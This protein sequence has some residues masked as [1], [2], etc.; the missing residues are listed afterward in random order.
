MRIKTTTQ[1]LRARVTTSAYSLATRATT[2]ALNAQAHAYKLKISVGT[3]GSYLFFQDNALVQSLT[4]LFFT[5]AGIVDNAAFTD[6]DSLNIGKNEVD[7][8]TVSEVFAKV[9]AKGFSDPFSIEDGGLYF[10]EDYTPLGYTTP[11]QPLILFGKNVSDSASFT[12]ALGVFTIGKGIL[13]T[14]SFT[15]GIALNKSKLIET[16]TGNISESYAAAFSN[17]ASDGITVAQSFI[18]SYSKAVA[19]GAAWSDSSLLVVGSAV[20]D[21]LGLGDAGSIRAQ[22]YCSFDYFAADYVGTSLTF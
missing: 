14:P 11:K 17:S 2:F 1:K 18:S 3:F 15:D 4:N 8:V 5:K 20:Q 6:D 13:D 19:D 9:Q 10:L 16:D 12:D 22:G 7:G 21:G